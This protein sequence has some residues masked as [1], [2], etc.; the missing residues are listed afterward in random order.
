[1]HLDGG[2]LG[3]DL[4]VVATGGDGTYPAWVGRS[5][6]GAMVRVTVQTAFDVD[7]GA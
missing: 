1:M 2:S 7:L 4:A 6:S 5:A 3:A